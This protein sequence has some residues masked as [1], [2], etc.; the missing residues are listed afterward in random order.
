MQ[1][2]DRASVVLFFT[3][4]LT[5]SNRSVTLEIRLPE[6]HESR[7][8]DVD[9]EP[10]TFA[11]VVE[12]FERICTAVE[13]QTG[14]VERQAVALES[15]L[16]VVRE[17]QAKRQNLSD[18]AGAGPTDPCTTPARGFSLSGSTRRD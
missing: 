18:R 13:R 6:R 17:E 11:D 5:M 16:A 10:A 7:H 9:L 1:P 4:W 2:N 14:A 8:V 12:A 3:P 15:I